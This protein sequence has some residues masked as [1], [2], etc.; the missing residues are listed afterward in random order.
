MKINNVKRWTEIQTRTREIM[1]PKEETYTVEVNR[2]VANID[3]SL[4]DLKRIAKY[5]GNFRSRDYIYADDRPIFR[6]L[7]EDWEEWENS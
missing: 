7:W 6:R 1:V 5:G 4:S 3:I 2:E